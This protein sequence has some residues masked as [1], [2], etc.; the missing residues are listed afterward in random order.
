MIL[1]YHKADTPKFLFNNKAEKAYLVNYSGITR[2]YRAR[3]SKDSKS[4]VCAC[5][6]TDGGQDH[7][8]D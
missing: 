8:K 3:L 1:P 7:R 6:Q 2:L 5:L 4:D